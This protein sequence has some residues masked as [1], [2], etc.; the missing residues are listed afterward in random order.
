VSVSPSKYL[1][2]RCVWVRPAYVR[3]RLEDAVGLDDVRVREHLQD[4]QLFLDVGY[5]RLVAR[6]AGLHHVDFAVLPAHRL[7]QHSA[8]ALAQRLHH[9]ELLFEGRRPRQPHALLLGRG[10]LALL[11]RAVSV[12]FVVR[13]LLVDARLGFNGPVQLPV[14]LRWESERSRRLERW[15]VPV[16]AVCR[17]RVAAV[18]ADLDFDDSVVGQELL[19]RRVQ[20]HLELA[21]G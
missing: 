21:V 16:A 10:A 6:L 9:R 7:P 19:F 17:P 12:L 5:G 14:R 2:S 18:V 13:G 15:L 4:L 8:P 11:L 3:R 1:S 20:S